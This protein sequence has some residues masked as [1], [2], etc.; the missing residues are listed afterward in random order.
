[1][2]I[3]GRTVDW[4]VIGIFYFLVGTGSFTGIICAV[5]VY[6][7]LTLSLAFV[8]SGFLPSWVVFSQV[9]LF[10]CLESPPRSCWFVLFNA[11]LDIFDCRLSPL[12]RSATTA[13]LL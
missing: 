6:T 2:T 3:D 10:C 7:K 13:A 11:S 5:Q 1:M 4:V 12:M 8:C 9:R